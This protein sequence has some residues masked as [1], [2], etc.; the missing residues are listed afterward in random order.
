MDDPPISSQY[1]KVMKRPENFTDNHQQ[2]FPKIHLLEWPNQAQFGS[3][4]QHKHVKD[5]EIVTHEN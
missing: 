2:K 5:I 4:I 3:R 1:F